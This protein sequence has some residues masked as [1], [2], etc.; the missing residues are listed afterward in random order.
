MGLATTRRTRIV[1]ALLALAVAAAAFDGATLWRAAQT[2]AAI[3]AGEPPPEAPGQPPELRF[4]RAYVQAQAASGARDAALNR[5]RALQSDPRVGAAA[6]YNS[7]NLLVRQAV[8]VRASTQ[9]GQAIALLEL[10]KEYYRDV[11]RADPAQ[12][13]A[14]Y[15]LERAQR[16]LP[17]PDDDEGAA[18]GQ[19]RNRERAV[20]TMR[21]YAPG[22]P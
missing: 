10:A 6:R 4:A 9:P 2:N 22:L 16:L 1:I 14:R 5:Y 12:W 8:E 20:T 11:L 13:D 21:G 19:E 3:A 18:P 17:D 15:N 7:A